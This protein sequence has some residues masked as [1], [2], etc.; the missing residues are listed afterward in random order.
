MFTLPIHKQRY[1]VHVCV[2]KDTP[3]MVTNQ[4]SSPA[5]L[6]SLIDAIRLVG[7]RCLVPILPFDQNKRQQ[8]HHSQLNRESSSR[9]DTDGTN[10]RVVFG[11]LALVIH[12]CQP[13]YSIIISR[14][15]KISP[16]SMA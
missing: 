11:L 10:K 13:H 6:F 7:A 3:G 9:G 4:G 5:Y 12:F 8:H 2:E 16:V 14:E 1:V 15:V